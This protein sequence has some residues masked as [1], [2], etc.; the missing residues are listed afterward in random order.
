[1]GDNSRQLRTFRD[2]Y[3]S[4]DRAGCE[5][6]HQIASSWQRSR[7]AGV[8]P[9]SVVVPYRPISEGVNSLLVQA[10]APVLDRVSE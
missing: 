1:M 3:L 2:D 5:L 6:R 7:L 8:D 9:D 4:G 10:A